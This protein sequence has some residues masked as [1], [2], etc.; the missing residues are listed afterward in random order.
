MSTDVSPKE[1]AP[2]DPNTSCSTPQVRHQLAPDW[3]KE[4]PHPPRK[5]CRTELAAAWLSLLGLAGFLIWASTWLRPPHATSLVLIGASYADNLAVPHNVYGMDALGDLEALTHNQE[6]ESFWGRGLL[7]LKR[8]PIELD[9]DVQWDSEMNGFKERSVVFFMAMHGAGDGQGGYLLYNDATLADDDSSRLRLDDVIDCLSQLPDEKHKLLVLDATQI[10]ADWHLGILHND[11]A[12]ELV[13]LAP[14]IE[15]IP[16]LVVIC[17]SDVDQRSWVCAEYQRS[18]FAYYFVE[19]LKGAAADLNNDGRINVWELHNYTSNQVQRWAAVNR[20][21]LQT[22]LLLPH[23]ELGEK[24]A[25]HI[26]LAIVRENYNP[27]DPHLAP[28]FVPPPDLKKAWET[29]QRLAAQSPPPYVYMPQQWRRYQD[30]L[31]RYEQLIEAGA[32]DAAAEM[33]SRLREQVFHLEQGATLALASLQNSLWMP[34]AAGF[35]AKA[36]DGVMQLVNTL[37]NAQ[38]ASYAKLWSDRIKTINS[39]VDQDLFRLEVSRELIQRAAEDPASNLAK[40]AAILTALED[41]LHPNPAEVHFLLM[42]HEFIP[43]S[44][45]TGSKSELVRTALETRQMAEKSALAYGTTGSSYSAEIVPWIQPWVAEGDQSRRLGEDLLFAGPDQLDKAAE[46]LSTAR[47]KYQQAMSA[48]GHV[49]SAVTLRNHVLEELPYY[50]KWLAGRISGETN[51]SEEQAML[52]ETEQLWRSTH[53]LVY[54]LQQQKPEWIEQAPPPTLSDIAPLSLVEQT[55]EV[56]KGVDSLQ[57]H[58]RQ[59]WQRLAAVETPD[60]YVNATMALAVPQ[61]DPEFR[62]RV[63][64]SKRRASRKLLIDANVQPAPVSLV[65]AE[66]Q[67]SLAKSMARREGRLALAVLGE[68]WFDACQGNNFESYDQVSHRL[69]VFEVEENWWDSLAIA[70]DQV[71]QRWLR[72]PATM[73]KLV[74]ESKH[75][76]RATAETMLCHAD[77]LSRKVAGT[78][79]AQM[80]TDPAELFRNLQLQGLIIWQAKRSF[81]D[82]WFSIDPNQQPY[83]QRVG[84]VYLNDAQ[85]LDSHWDDI[86]ALRKKLLAPGTIELLG[87]SQFDVTTQKQFFLNY[88]LQASEG[89]EIPLGYPVVWFEANKDLQLVEPRA[90]IRLVRELGGQQPPATIRCTVTNM[91]QVNANDAT[92]KPAL[93]T[94]GPAMDAS[95]ITAQGLFRGQK[96]D[97]QTPVNL[98]L[99]AQVTVDRMP[100]PKIGSLAVRASSNLQ[101]QY[102]DGTGAI[103]IVLDCSGSMGPQPGASFTP[104]TKYAEATKALHDVL[105]QVPQGVKVSLWVFG[106]AMGSAKTVSQAEQTIERI[107]DPE[108]WSSQQLAKLM[109]KVKY[110]TIEPWNESP[111]VRTMLAAKNDLANA[112][113]FKSLVVITDGMDNR[114]AEDTAF[115]PNH[116]DIPTK[117]IEAFG[118]SGI[119]VNVVGFKVETPEQSEAVRQFSVVESFFP[120]GKYLQVNEAGQLAQT[121]DA[122]LRQHLRYW[123]EDYSSKLVQG[124][125][126]DGLDMSEA[127][128]NDRWFAPGLSPATY[129]LITHTK[130]LISA[131]VSIN[132]GDLLLIQLGATPGGYAFQRLS[133][134]QSVYPWRPWETSAGWRLSLLQNQLLDNNN[135]QMLVTLEQP[136]AGSGA[137]RIMQLRP[138]KVWFEVSPKFQQ[139]SVRSR[140]SYQPGYPAPA[141]S[142]DVGP[143]P[144]NATD[145]SAAPPNLK[146]WWSPDNDSPGSVRLVRNQD[147]KGLY[148]LAGKQVNVSGITVTIEE[149]TVEERTVVTS[150]GNMKQQSC[151]VMRLKFPPGNAVWARAD[152]MMLAG[153]QDMLFNDIGRA[154]CVF[155]PVT[156][157]QVDEMLSGWTLTSLNTFKQRAEQRGYMLDMDN[158]PAPSPEDYRPRS[159]FDFSAVQGTSSGITPGNH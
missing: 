49:R 153:G 56:Q 62:M 158:L 9:H 75:N 120:P 42:L 38:P 33:A 130:G 95:G 121:L 114:F 92:G 30:T 69:E 71:Q 23:D 24:R 46:L 67:R 136:P 94:S 103:A 26:D 108:P 90:D 17:A 137:T 84:T 144:T 22:P 88:K 87:P 76:D 93:S 31:I 86:A 27:P 147:F 105:S 4:P 102:G 119:V 32:K 74:D 57:R 3:T 101:Q 16:N 63:L 125:P 151:L 149:A 20:R 66:Y 140:W 148:D 122:A 159:V 45:L 139:N 104:Q 150:P 1:T 8:K 55:A 109:A 37:W 41:P 40:S 44:A 13:E 141:Y 64:A 123:I 154:T 79:A 85:R 59:R 135:A 131:D 54:L 97:A 6:T 60:T 157:D 117:L 133:Y 156:R 73:Q 145:G 100:L 107:L 134:A 29:R 143:W 14:R 155:W 78:P 10:N 15:S 98:Y 113:G 96:L 129:S 81:S 82:H 127:G 106:Q 124:V 28:V 25:S 19:G 35:A 21:S 47:E 34:S 11:F 80:S 118:Q 111:I 65:T 72:M 61:G 142:L 58:F 91:E 2:A 53:R 115:N 50:S 132:R 52:C 152:G 43:H 39:T 138:A 5:L 18:I 12:R 36:P 48:A 89:A 7:N 77:L 70:G 83:Y 51:A 146:V 126:T 112:Q 128:S 116:V 99:D 110:P 68:R